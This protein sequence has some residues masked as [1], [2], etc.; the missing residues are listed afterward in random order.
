MSAEFPL[1]IEERGGGHLQFEVNVEHWNNYFPVPWLACTIVWLSYSVRSLVI[2]G[3]LLFRRAY[4]IHASRSAFGRS[5]NGNTR[6]T[7]R[8]N[9]Y[10]TETL[11]RLPWSFNKDF[12]HHQSLV[13]KLPSNFFLNVNSKVTIRTKKATSRIFCK[14]L[15][16]KCLRRSTLYTED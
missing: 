4:V 6:S 9:R 12:S 13:G 15:L 2:T 11:C 8:A 5:T 10:H 7:I 16:C 3:T 14:V 1:R